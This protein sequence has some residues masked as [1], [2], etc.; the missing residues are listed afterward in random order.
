MA[1]N[2]RLNP[3]WYPAKQNP[4]T[5]VTAS[6]Q[7][8]ADAPFPQA[9]DAIIERQENELFFHIRTVSKRSLCINRVSAV[10]GTVS[11]AQRC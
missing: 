5:V 6:M 10:C 11:Q 2:K 7:G 8:T 3:L 1:M 4:F 9:N